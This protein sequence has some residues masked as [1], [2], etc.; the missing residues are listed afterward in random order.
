MYNTTKINCDETPENWLSVIDS[1]DTQPVLEIHNSEHQTAH[2][3]CASKAS[4]KI[5]I[6]TLSEAYDR[7]P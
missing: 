4:M 5:L 3:W 1:D 7:M 2:A 6:E